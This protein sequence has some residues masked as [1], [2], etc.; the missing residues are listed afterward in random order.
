[1]DSS[2][3]NVQTNILS[4]T[5]HKIWLNLAGVIPI[6]TNNGI[7]WQQKKCRKHGWSKHSFNRLLTLHHIFFTLLS[8]KMTLS[9]KRNFE[10][11]FL[12]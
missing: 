1:M 12:L 8:P 4:C 2:P 6:F 3:K 10:G 9:E 7:K 11:G 5:E